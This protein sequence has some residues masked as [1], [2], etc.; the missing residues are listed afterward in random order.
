MPN[1]HAM[2]TATASRNC[3]SAAFASGPIALRNHI[4][5]ATTLSPGDG[6]GAGNIADIVAGNVGLGMYVMRGSVFSNS[7]HALIASGCFSIFQRAV[8]IRNRVIGLLFLSSWSS[9]GVALVA[10]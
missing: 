2:P 3:G 6:C 7:M 10:S 8:A 9:A 4:A 5:C 1:Q